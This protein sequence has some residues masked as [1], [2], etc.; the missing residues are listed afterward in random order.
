MSDL[1]QK[2]LR[3]LAVETDSL[4]ELCRGLHDKVLHRVDRPSPKTSM[5]VRRVTPIER[6]T[7]EPILARLKVAQGT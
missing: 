6:V 5:E 7:P 1:E 4:R 3:E 2:A